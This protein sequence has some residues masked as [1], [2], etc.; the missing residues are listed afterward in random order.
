MASLLSDTGH[1]LVDW[2]AIHWES[3]EARE[4]IEALAEGGEGRDHRDRDKAVGRGNDA[5]WSGGLGG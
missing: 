2:D 5:R 4:V 3:S 1:A